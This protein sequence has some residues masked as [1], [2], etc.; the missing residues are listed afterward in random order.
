MILLDVCLVGWIVVVV[1][2]V[3]VV[4]SQKEHIEATQPNS[5]SVHFYS[6]SMETETHTMPACH[7]DQPFQACALRLLSGL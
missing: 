7:A 1:V 6:Q 3:V 2:V 5:S 4:N